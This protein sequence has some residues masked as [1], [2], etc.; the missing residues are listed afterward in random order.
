MA[1]MARLESD[2]ESLQLNSPAS[3]PTH[4]FTIRKSSD[5]LVTHHAANTTTQTEIEVDHYQSGSPHTPTN[6][7]IGSHRGIGG[8]QVYERAIIRNCP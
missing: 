5:V 3:D 2:M 7:T 4:H 8:R 1:H 6:K